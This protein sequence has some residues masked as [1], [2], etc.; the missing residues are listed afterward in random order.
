VQTPQLKKAPPPGA[1]KTPL[2]AAAGEAGGELAEMLRRR[3]EKQAAS[4]KD[5]A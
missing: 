2:A 3:A 4:E 1:V 5:G